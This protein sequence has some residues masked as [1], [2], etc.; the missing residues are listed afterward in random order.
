MSDEQE[1]NP[2]E[3]F[4][5][6]QEILS[7]IEWEDELQD[8]SVASTA[9]ALF[10]SHMETLLQA[11]MEIKAKKFSRFLKDV[12]L[13]IARPIRALHRVREYVAGEPT[14]ELARRVQEDERMFEAFEERISSTVHDLVNRVVA[15]W[16]D[17][18]VE[19]AYSA[20]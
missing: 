12:V 6:C 20:L 14:S 19:Y 8:H 3:T 1:I 13:I 10:D 17:H 11:M 5:G 4:L 15:M 18:Q 16:D 9:I 7:T 2:R